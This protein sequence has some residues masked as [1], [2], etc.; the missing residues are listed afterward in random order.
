MTTI[1][2]QLREA[3]AEIER[4]RALLREAQRECVGLDPT[5]CEACG[6]VDTHGDGCIVQRI[7]EALK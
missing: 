6:G 4:L 3:H 2:D 7:A 1:Q 5:W